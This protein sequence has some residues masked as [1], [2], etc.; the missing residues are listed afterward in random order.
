MV[1]ERSFHKKWPDYKHYEYRL[2]CR[3]C[4]WHTQK[5]IGLEELR[6][7]FIRQMQ[8]ACNIDWKPFQDEDRTWTAQDIYWADKVDCP[9]E[10]LEAA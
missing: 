6:S 1:M 5:F 3:Y 9:T 7:G 10:R 2:W 8:T 4:D